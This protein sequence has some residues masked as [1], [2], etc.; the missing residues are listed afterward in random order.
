[1]ATIYQ[2]ASWCT[3]L[4]K[5]TVANW[6]LIIPIFTFLASLVGNGW[7]F[8]EVQAKQEQIKATQQQ[9]AQVAEAYRP[10]VLPDKPSKEPVKQVIK[11]VERTSDIPQIIEKCREV[12]KQEV[13]KIKDELIKRYHR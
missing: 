1:M 2:W 3:D 11:V 6:R 12:S 9:V 7:Q 8:T 5:W 4:L 13:Q 10:Y